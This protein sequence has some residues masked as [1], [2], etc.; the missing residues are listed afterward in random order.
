MHIHPSTIRTSTNANELCS[1][2]Y[3]LF[4]FSGVLQIFFNNPIC[5]SFE[6]VMQFVIFQVTCEDILGEG[7]EFKLQLEVQTIRGLKVEIIENDSRT[8]SVRSLV[9]GTKCEIKLTAKNEHSI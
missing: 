7:P 2:K 1:K 6:T 9:P 4:I 8:F 5:N 3:H